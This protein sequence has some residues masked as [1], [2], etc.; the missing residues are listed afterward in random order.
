MAAAMFVCRASL[1]LAGD[2]LNGRSD[3]LSLANWRS[4]GATLTAL[5]HT[6]LYNHCRT[7]RR[8]VIGAGAATIAATVD[9]F[10][11]QSTDGIMA[12]PAVPAVAVT[13]CNACFPT[14]TATFHDMR[15]IHTSQRQLHAASKV[16]TKIS[17]PCRA[18]SIS[19]V[20]PTICQ[21]RSRRRT[22]VKTC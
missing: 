12:V 2:S 10:Q 9:A 22:A 4:T 14:V 5:V 17:K 20:Q 16:Q 8:Q 21:P 19:A 7:K 18:K 3:V 1:A 13:D 15:T 6:E 11:G